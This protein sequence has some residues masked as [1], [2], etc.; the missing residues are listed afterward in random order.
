MA[1][2]PK[3]LKAGRGD[4]RRGQG[5][6]DQGGCRQGHTGHH[7]ENAAEIRGRSDRRNGAGLHRRQPP[8]RRYRSDS[9]ER[10]SDRGEEIREVIQ[11]RELGNFWAS[12]EPGTRVYSPNSTGTAGKSLGTDSPN[13]WIRDRL[14]HG[15]GKR[16][17]QNFR[18]LRPWQGQ[19]CWIKS[20]AIRMSRPIFP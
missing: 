9:G 10:Q 20:G 16:A 4:H 3:K 6:R 5:S 18:M 19:A 13:D 7:G 14:R 12:L 2:K 8:W 15:A 1:H 11:G 17:R